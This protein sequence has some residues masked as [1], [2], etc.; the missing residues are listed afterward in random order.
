VDTLLRGY[1]SPLPMRDWAGHESRM[2]P[3]WQWEFNPERAQELLAEAGY[4]DGFSITLTPAIRNAPA[5]VEACEAVASMWGDIGVD[6]DFQ[7]TPYTTLRPSLISREYVGGTC[8]SVAI[9]LVVAIGASNY[10]NESVFSY[11]THHPMLD[12]LVSTATSE[13]DPVKRQQ[14]EVDIY[15]WMSDNVMAFGLYSF[16]AVWPVGPRIQEWQPSGYADLRKIN[17]YE[18]IQPR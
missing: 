10:L 5:E 18:Y 14:L 1:G 3:E 12:K 6:V 15:Q 8:H 9:R 11:G 16:N 17:G 2:P 7:R 4:E 13:V